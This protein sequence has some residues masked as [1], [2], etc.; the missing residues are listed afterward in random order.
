MQKRVL[1]IVGLLV[2]ICIALGGWYNLYYI[3]TPEYSINII[4]EAIKKH[5]VDRFKKH[6]DLDSVVAHTVDDYMAVKQ[7]NSKDKD[8]LGIEL[9]AALKPQITTMLK[10]EIVSIVDTG[11]WEVDESSKIVDKEIVISDINLKGVNVKKVSY[12]KNEGDFP[13]L[14]VEIETPALPDAYI[15]DFEMKK[16]DDGSWRITRITNFDEYTQK[17][18]DQKKE[19]LKKYIADTKPYID[20]NNKKWAA[21]AKLDRKV[22]YAKIAEVCKERLDK[23]NTWDVPYGAKE[24]NDLR[25]EVVSIGVEVYTYRNEYENSDKSSPVSREMMEKN[26]EMNK[27]DKKVREIIKEATE[28]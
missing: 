4:Q 6:V 8:E 22:K 28:N 17:I 15:M 7:K 16:N 1:Y 2:L 26:Y 19:D 9:V 3:K 13:H 23:L 24:L 14:G 5:D 25:K 10:D 12:V 21:A 11:S 27:T 18:I 20:E